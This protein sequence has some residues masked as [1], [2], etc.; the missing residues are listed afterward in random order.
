M[1]LDKLKNLFGKFL[2]GKGKGEVKDVNYEE[3]ASRIPQLA[4]IAQ[5]LTEALE[6]GFQLSD[7]GVL[8][9]IIGPCMELADEIEKFSG[10]EKKEFVLDAAWLTY[11]TIDTYPDGKQNNINLPMMAGGF[12]RAVERRL[13]RACAQWAIEAV[14]DQRKKK[15]KKT[16]SVPTSDS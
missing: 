1:K 4:E 12:E 9:K 5:I 15:R 3:L 8:A 6:D 13:V 7:L 11:R 10:K 2:P 16:T 14:Y